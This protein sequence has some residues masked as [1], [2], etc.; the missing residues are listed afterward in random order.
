MQ[1]MRGLTFEI[2]ECRAMGLRGDTDVWEDACPPRHV[3][4]RSGLPE[5]RYSPGLTL[6]SGQAEQFQCS[7]DNAVDHLNCDGELRR[8]RRLKAS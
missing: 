8:S 1:S 4:L 2:V 6:P 5:P 7:C 3:K